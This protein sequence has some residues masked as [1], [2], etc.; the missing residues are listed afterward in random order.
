MYLG[1]LESRDH[2]E[3]TGAKQ[4]AVSCQQGVDARP[5]RSLYLDRLAESLH[6]HSLCEA[7]RNEKTLLIIPPMATFEISIVIRSPSS[8]HLQGCYHISSW[9]SLISLFN[10]FKSI[11]WQSQA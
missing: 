9:Q 10:S 5:D 11:F 3:S 4:V 1:K 7:I 2:L 6:L 8:N